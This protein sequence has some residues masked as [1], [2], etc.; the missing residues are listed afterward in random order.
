MLDKV[1]KENPQK[2]YKE[3][4][5]MH[6]GKLLKDTRFEVIYRFT[7][8]GSQEE[9]EIIEEFCADKNTY[10]CTFK[11]N[12]FYPAC[13]LDF[14]PYED[15]METCCKRLKKCVQDGIMHDRFKCENEEISISPSSIM[16]YP[17]ENP[18]S[19]AFYNKQTAFR[20]LKS[21]I[22]GF[23]G[24]NFVIVGA[25]IVAVIAELV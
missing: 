22:V 23:L 5:S 11:T 13:T 6:E 24:I 21:L 25:A 1:I 14:E 20:T 8:R 12:Y 17:R 19:W 4:N 10:N 9:E 3:P 7:Q 15:G 16:K 2:I 18:K